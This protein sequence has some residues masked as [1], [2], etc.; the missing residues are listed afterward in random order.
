M[1]GITV[2]FIS[3]VTIIFLISPVEKSFA[4]QVEPVFDEIAF[5]NL[6]VG[7]ADRVATDNLL[8]DIAS[9]KKT[10]AS[11][12]LRA[13]VVARGLADFV[14]VLEA[15]GTGSVPEPQKIKEL[16]DKSL[17]ETLD[18]EKIK[19][20]EK[21]F[22]SLTTFAQAGSESAQQVSQAVSETREIAASVTSEVVSVVAETREVQSQL[23]EEQRL[24]DTTNDQI[25]LQELLA[26]TSTVTDA[27]DAYY[28]AH[29]V[30]GST[31]FSQ[32]VKDNANNIYENAQ[33]DATYIANAGSGGGG[34]G[35]S[36]VDATYA[37][38][39]A[40]THATLFEAPSTGVSYDST[41][42]D[43]SNHHSCFTCS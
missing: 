18:A 16:V 37:I 5:D 10:D 29:P 22:E 40:Q 19:V 28:V 17:K 38:E 26:A 14:E 33:I 24:D 8:S 25:A 31:S 23:R 9:G 7:Q 32:T 20:S 41:N 36:H 4:Q 12:E 43:E 2:F 30:L 34:H 11:P 39:N 1:R 6:L 27:L 15:P 21:Q 42:A 13:A 35:G 3:I